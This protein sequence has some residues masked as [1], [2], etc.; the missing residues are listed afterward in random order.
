MVPLVAT[1][2]LGC[3]TTPAQFRNPFAA[4]YPEERPFPDSRFMSISSVRLHHRIWEPAQAA[5]GKLLLLPTEGGSTATYRLLAEELVAAGY[6][7]LAVDLPAFGFSSLA[8]DFEHSFEARASLL[9][10]LADRVDTESNGF[11]PTR[12]WSIVGHGVGGQLG[13][14]MAQQRPQRTEHLILIGADVDSV[15]DPAGFMWFPPVRWALRA[16]L[17][18]SLYTTEGVR[19]LLGDA[20]GRPATD[21]EVAL[22]AAPLLREGMTNAYINYRRTAGRVEFRLEDVTTPVLLLSGDLDE[23]VDP[24]SLDRAAERFSDARRVTVAGAAHL[25][26]ETHVRETAAAILAQVSAGSAEE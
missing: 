8:M 17:N 4:Q 21:A 3:A 13:V 24:E 6:A 10:S 5:E 9:W 14:V 20:Y 15:A 23:N 26:M 16:W 2:L 22:Y 12:G 25:P 7:V 11:A 1:M 18:E 19:E